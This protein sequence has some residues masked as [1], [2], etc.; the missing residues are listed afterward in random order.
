MDDPW[1]RD[2]GTSPVSLTWPGYQP[3]PDPDAELVAAVRDVF[4]VSSVRRI[5]SENARRLGGLFAG[6]TNALEIRGRFIVPSG[7]AYDVVSPRFRDLGCITLFRRAGAD[8]LIYAVPGEAPA[9]RTRPWLALALFVATALSVL[10]IGGVNESGSFTEINLLAGLPYAVSLLAI[11]VAHESGHYLMARRKG[12]PSSLPFLIPM[13]IPPIGTM[14]AVMQMKAP[15]KNRSALLA[16]GAAGPIAGLILAIPILVLGLSLS[17]VQAT[18]AVYIQEGNSLLYAALKF[19]VKGQLLPSNGLDVML[20]PVAW[21]GWTGL[22]ITSL[23]LIPAGQLDGGHMAYV[24]LGRRARYLTMPIIVIL[25]ALG[26]TL[27]QGWLLWAFLVFFFGQVHATPLDDVT[28]ISP[29]E[30]AVALLLLVVFVLVFMPVP[31]GLV[32]AQ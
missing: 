4:A 9:D 14:G 17:T 19:I 5:R 2:K 3:T 23:N 25:V 18:P 24:L 28:P 32:G 10:Y 13:P 1:L 30:R 20:H 22:L 21:A 31:I 8:Q 6:P 15:P 16:V 11:I 27:W 7:R 29:R 26:L 12:V